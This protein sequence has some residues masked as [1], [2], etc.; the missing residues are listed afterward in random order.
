MRRVTCIIAAVITVASAFASEPV[1]AEIV[2]GRDLS[3]Y[4]AGGVYRTPVNGE[5]ITGLERLRQFVWSH[6]SHKRRGYVEFVFQ[7][8]DAGRGHYFFIEPAGNRWRIAWVEQSY[9]I[10][11]GYS[12]PPPQFHRD[13]VTVERC[14]GALIFFDAKDRVVTYL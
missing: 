4:E 3:A 5:E 1:P 9:S 13:I 8:T 6:W 7:D 12:P 11:P 14:R 2:K 10:L